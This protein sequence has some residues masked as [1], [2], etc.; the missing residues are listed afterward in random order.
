MA[1]EYWAKAYV[2][3]DAMG[4][5]RTDSALVRVMVG[6]RDNDVEAADK[7][8]LHFMKNSFR[9]IQKQLPS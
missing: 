5:N 6:V 7:A 4:S 3:L 9:D 2:V 8:A 1:S